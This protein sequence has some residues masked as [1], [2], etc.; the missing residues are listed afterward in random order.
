M[1]RWNFRAVS[2]MCLVVLLSSCAS[3]FTRKECEKLN[4]YQVGFD[5]ALRGDRISNDD[6]V[7]KCRKADAEISESQ[8]DVGFKAGMN[9]YCQPDG[10]FQTGKSGELFNTEFCEPGQIS[11]LRKRHQDGLTA[12]CQDG[13]TAG[14]SGKKYKNVCAPA[15]EKG[16]L[17]EYR[18]GR[19]KYLQ[20]M[21]QNS[22]VKVRELNS[23]IDRLSLEKRITDTRLS[24][25]PYVKTGD[26]DP[27]VNERSRLNNQSWSLS[28]NLSQST[29]QRSKLQTELDNLKQELV[30]LD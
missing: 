21:I 22:E 26:Q 8:L 27:F 29:Q 15:L 14:L 1:K 28:S 4:W 24:A 25:L 2:L 9:R 20:G 13:H 7:S 5:A 16:F 6:V 30:T 12:Y 19:K 10:V 17:P 23:D 18:K 11:F 3:Y